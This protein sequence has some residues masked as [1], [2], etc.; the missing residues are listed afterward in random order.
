MKSTKVLFF[1]LFIA[2]M[3]AMPKSAMS[4]VTIGQDKEP[5]PFSVLELISNSTMG[6]RL[7]QLK[8]KERDNLRKTSTFIAEENGLAKGLTIYNTD[9]ECVQY[10]NGEKWTAIGTC[11]YVIT[12]VEMPKAAG[13]AGSDPKPVTWMTYNLGAATSA[14]IGANTYDLTTPKGQ[15]KWLKDKGANG[16]VARNDATV[17][18]GWWQWG[19]KDW[20]HAVNTAT[21]IRYI[22]SG[23]NAT[24]GTV[25]DVTL[26][27]TTFWQASSNWYTGSTPAK[28][29]LWGNGKAINVGSA[30]DDGGNPYN[31]QYYQQPKRTEYDPC[32]TGWRVPTQDEWETLAAYCDASDATGNFYPS[33]TNPQPVHTTYNPDLIWVPVANGLPDSSG[34]DYDAEPATKVG[35]YA[36][37]DKTE[38]VTYRAA[39]SSWATTVLYE[40]IV[41]A[42]SIPDP[43]LFLPAAGSR[44]GINGVAYN[45]GDTGCYWS[46]TVESTNSAWLLGFNNG[47]VYPFDLTRVDGMSVRCVAE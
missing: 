35:G 4:Q 32:P 15:M 41:G 34:W 24:T 43:L 26:A 13:C 45:V 37:Y 9:A 33:A 30:T 28:N 14:T 23:S 19:R 18:G 39:N 10:W 8:Q 42:V 25:N 7:P 44:Q 3:A 2:A 6:L 22:A 17:Y 46:S 20:E 47:H 11:Q 38:W 12:G 21:H 5:E 31:G 29:D 40:N 1:T 36:I 27:G 16:G